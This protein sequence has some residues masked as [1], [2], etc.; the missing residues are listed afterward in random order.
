MNALVRI[1]GAYREP[2]TQ[3]C[4]PYPAELQD[5]VRTT[6]RALGQ[7]ELTVEETG[8]QLRAAAAAALADDVFG[9]VGRCERAAG[10]AAGWA[11][12]ARLAVRT[13]RRAVP[14]QPRLSRSALLLW[15]AWAAAAAALAALFLVGLS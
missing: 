13:A 4:G 12:G 9:L 6:R 3:P 14:A 15:A 1:P 11:G 5:A 2:D 7:L 8:P 10:W